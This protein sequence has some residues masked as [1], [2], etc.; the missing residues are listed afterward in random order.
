MIDKRVMHKKLGI[1]ARVLCE[2]PSRNP[3]HSK[4]SNLWYDVQFENGECATWIVHDMVEIPEYASPQ[5]LKA[6]YALVKDR[7]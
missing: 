1:V 4:G 6:L 7:E 5:Q 2:W 3:L